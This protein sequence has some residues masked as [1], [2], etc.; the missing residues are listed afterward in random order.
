MRIGFRKCPGTGCPHTTASELS[1]VRSG[2]RRHTRIGF[3]KCPG[4]G[5]PHTTKEFS[6]VR[7]PQTHADW[8]PQVSGYRLFPHH[9]R[10]FRGPGASDTRRLGSPS[11]RVQAVPTPQLQEL[12]CHRSGSRRQKRIGFPKCPGTACPHSGIFGI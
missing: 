5:C 6:E 9:K 11:V 4:T 10:V 8:V 2:S 7:E 3:P 1:Q 12:S